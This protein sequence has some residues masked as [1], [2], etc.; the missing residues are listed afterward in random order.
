[1]NDLSL[2]KIIIENK[3]NFDDIKLRTAYALNLCTVSVSQIIDYEDLIVLEQEYETILNNLNIEMMPKD[4][5]LLK[6]LKQLLDTITFFRI[7]EGDKKFI[8]RDY[9]NKMKNAIWSAV[10][11][12]SVIF[13]GSGQ[14]FQVMKSL[15]AQVGIG[16]MNYRKTKAEINN[17]YEK[18]KWQLQR[19]AIE[20]FNGLRREL[21]DTAWRLVDAYDLPD[22]YR[23]TERQVKQYN[24]ILMDSDLV[25]RFERL[26]TIKK[27]FVAYPQFWYF[28]GNT[29]NK[30]SRLDSCGNPE[31]YIKVA[32][33]CY[34]VFISEFK[35]CRLLRENQVASAG[36]LEYI[37]LLDERLS[38][39]K[40]KIEDLIEFAV[41]MSGGANDVL[42]LCVF[43]YIKIH[44]FD[45]A[46]VLLRRLINEGYN[47]VVNAQLLSGYYVSRYM[48][49]DDKVKQEYKY[50]EERVNEKYLVPMLDRNVLT[51]H[52]ESTE[53]FIEDSFLKNQKKILIEKYIMVIDL[54]RNKYLY[55]FNKCIPVPTDKIY[56]DEYYD[57]SVD[58]YA[59]RKMDGMVL[60][61][62]IGLYSYVSKLR[63]CDYPY[64]YLLVL[65][66]M[67]NSIFTLDCVQGG[68]SHFLKT[69]SSPILSKRAILKGYRENIDD[70][71]KFSIETY[72]SM[73]E[74]SFDDFT[75]EFFE[76]LLSYISAYI[77]LKKDV[78]S[79]N[80]AEES[81]R[82]FCIQQG[83]DTPDILFEEADNEKI[84]PETKKQFLGIE[85]IDDGI[86][87]SEI[88]NRHQ[89]IRRRLSLFANDISK[90]PDKCR[91]ILSGEEEFD[92]YFINLDSLNKREIRRKTVAIL[93]DNTVRDNDLLYT[94]EGLIQIIKGKMKQTIP[95]NDI[96]LNA[97]KNTIIIR[98]AYVNPNVD[99]NKLIKTISVLKGERF[100]QVKK[101]S[102]VKE[103]KNIINEKF[104]EFNII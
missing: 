81:L 42:Q 4:E 90:N 92:R 88:D 35:S 64:N 34:E 61:N 39:E 31:Y 102:G 22:E 94:T 47:R 66:D 71:S 21:F 68:E 9:Q 8:E 43:P 17:A 67:L 101:D 98:Q 104:K 89:D 103:L 40:E 69:L 95:Y 26:N 32:K 23:L 48:Q 18:Q 87:T 49:G 46:A 96:K 53:Q 28:F 72:N 51:N 80:N 97:E 1:M 70:E 2:D 60:K 50:L 85:L 11:N 84:V 79:M 54:F 29:A 82:N 58:S 73:L 52:G 99:M 56:T 36:A 45:K 16:Y 14:N 38:D 75:T 10:P 78:I 12:F 15:A 100:M 6:I 65:N 76:S 13:S 59:A 7:Q 44:K 93:D 77:E 27:Y 30:I 62:K 55:A 74:L 41:E 24:E 83:F 57:G 5:A 25:R 63:E 3:A 33:A 19:A 20:Q 37:D 86:M 91:F